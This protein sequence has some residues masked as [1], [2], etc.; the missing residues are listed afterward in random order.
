M[1]QPFVTKEYFEGVAADKQLKFD[2][3]GFTL[4]SFTEGLVY[5]LDSMGDVV[6]ADPS[7]GLVL[8]IYVG[9]NDQ[10]FP[11]FEQ[12]YY[13]S[14]GAFT[15]RG[16]RWYLDA[17]GG[18]T[19]TPNDALFGIAV[20][21]DTLLIV[22]NG[23]DTGGI[24]SGES[25]TTSNE[26]GGA[27]LAL[28]KAGV[29]LPFRTFD[30]PGG[31]INLTE[32]GNLLEV[33]VDSASLGVDTLE[34]STP[35]LANAEDLD[36][37]SDVAGGKPFVDLTNNSPTAEIEVDKQINYDGLSGGA[38]GQPTGFTFDR[39]IYRAC[40]VI[41]TI[42]KTGGELE[43]GHIMI[44]H[45][46]SVAGVVVTRRGT[47]LAPFAQGDP[48]VTFSAD[49]SGNDC[50]LLYD[51][52]NGDDFN[53]QVKPRPIR[54]NA[55][56]TVTVEFV[57]ATS[58]FDH[59]VDS[60]NQ[61]IGV[62]ITTSDGQPLVAPVSVDVRDLLTGTAPTPGA[63]TFSTPQTLNWSGGEANGTVKNAVINIVAFGGTGT[64]DLDLDN[65]SGA[66]EGA[67]NAHE[68]TI[69]GAST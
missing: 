3:T 25:N 29:N 12:L 57:N 65:A 20:D 22:W 50:R 68:V 28:P 14:T 10:G 48:G 5:A 8:G 64:V 59:S 62:Q 16:T 67:P 51:E 26:G 40:E 1:A 43:T 15:G 39:T 41:Y 52:V 33:D 45:D 53:L 55:P 66:T 31:T 4:P 6:A 27:E 35:I 13:T 38:S 46:D 63:Y 44:L 49:V 24:A 9:D 54:L 36:F 18:L 30:S 69:V 19:T 32:N 34:N 47:E 11:I 23:L 7:T 42:E 37:L 17:G 2:P 56:Q 61:D 60:G 21:E 58:F